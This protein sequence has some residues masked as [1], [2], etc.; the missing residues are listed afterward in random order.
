M[1][2]A[3]ESTKALNIGI[4]KGIWALIEKKPEPITQ[5]VVGQLDIIVKQLITNSHNVDKVLEERTGKCSKYVMGDIYYLMFR[6]EF[7]KLGLLNAIG[8]IKEKSKPIKLKKDEIIRIESTKTKLGKTLTFVNAYTFDFKSDVLFHQICE[9]G[10]IS[11]YIEI[12]GIT[13]IYLIKYIIKH[14]E[15]YGKEKYNKFVTGII[16]SFQRFYKACI[17]FVGIDPVNPQVKTK[18]AQQFFDDITEFYKIVEQQ[19]VLNGIDICMRMPELLVVA[20]HDKYLVTTSI[21]PREHQLEI[22]KKVYK[23]FHNGFFIL[24]N[25]MINTGKTTSVV[26]LGEI[27]KYYGKTLLCVCNMEPV[28]IQMANLCCFNGTK[29]AMASLKS[30]GKLKISPNDK[31]KSTIENIYVIICGAEVGNRLL[32]EGKDKY[33][34]FHDEP[35]IGADCENPKTSVSLYHNVSVMCNAPKWTIFSSATSPTLLEL[36]KLIT[37]LRKQYPTLVTD[38]VY[39]SYVQVGCEIRTF[40]GKLVVPY[41]NCSTKEDITSIISKMEDIPFI[42]RTLTPNVVVELHKSLILNGGIQNIP[43]I[44]EYFK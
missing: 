19:F 41:S 30:N 44:P 4:S 36:T 13:Y 43:N 26:P 3:D 34:L 9:N 16:I 29:F 21:R 42:S 15:V 33:I 17:D 28:R 14:Y 39:S 18:I 10:F 37:Y 27:A 32:L 35:T 8:E 38:K 12:I 25:A 1:A 7:V 22:L 11:N 31:T 5:Q 40:E 2:S 24:Y 20:P 23:H 6:P